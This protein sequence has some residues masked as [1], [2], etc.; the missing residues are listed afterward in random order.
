MSEVAVKDD[1][2]MSGENDE[3]VVVDPDLVFTTPPKPHLST[4]STVERTVGFQL[5]GQTYY[6]IKPRKWEDALMALEETAA[7]RATG[8]DVLWQGWDFLQTVV[9]PESLRRLMGRARD[10]SDD[11]ERS[12]LFD[13]IPKIIRKLQAKETAGKAAVPRPAR[14]RAARSAS[15]PRE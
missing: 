6:L 3:G 5:D 14:A 12:D 8:A 1:A 13:L 2:Q 4:E 11:F 9:T 7:R 10:D 15:A